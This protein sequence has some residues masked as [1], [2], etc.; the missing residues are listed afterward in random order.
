VIERGHAVFERIHRVDQG[1]N[2]ET[3]EIGNVA[4]ERQPGA[5]PAKRSHASIHF[6]RDLWNR[7]SALAATASA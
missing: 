6:L 1:C 2:G 3:P 4:C 7:D 5:R